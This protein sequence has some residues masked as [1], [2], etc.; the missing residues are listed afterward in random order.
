MAEKANPFS[1]GFSSRCT[2]SPVIAGEGVFMLHSFL[3]G[4]IIT[5]IYDLFRIF[6]RII[7]HGW[8][9]LSLED[10]V[11]WVLATAGIFYMLYYENNGMFRWFSVIGAGTGMFLYKKTLSTVLVNFVSGTI[12]KLIALIG[13]ILWKLSAPVRFLWR[14]MKILAGRGA[15]R[16][17]REARIRRRQIKYRLTAWKKVIKMRLCKRS[18]KRQNKRQIKEQTAKKQTGKKLKRGEAES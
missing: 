8:F 1:P 4:V 13:K 18:E 10:L 15:R 2:V 3:L 17:A 16:A 9:L 7:P 5:F 11:F 6:R 14:R 12:N